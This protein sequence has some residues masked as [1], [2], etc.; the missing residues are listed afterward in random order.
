MRPALLLALLFIGCAH[1]Q[2]RSEPLPELSRLAL[3]SRLADAS[4]DEGGG[5]F[6]P[7][8]PYYVAHETMAQA[9]PPVGSPSWLAQAHS[10]T[11]YGPYAL[12]IVSPADSTVA[13]CFDLATQAGFSIG[14]LRATSVVQMRSYGSDDCSGIG[15]ILTQWSVNVNGTIAPLFESTAASGS[16]GFALTTNGARLD[17]GT[18]AN[19]YLYSDGTQVIAQG[20]V[21]VSGN[22]HVRANILNDVGGVNPVE[23]NDADGFRLSSTAALPTCSVS[24]EGTFKRDGTT[25]AASTA[26]TRMCWCTSDGAASPAYAWVNSISGTVGTATTCAP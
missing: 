13:V 6:L 12:K 18:G 9:M 2:R 4:E 11:L 7:V 8:V 17:L 20:S 26:R 24:L 3:Q 23:V 15:T 5:G 14:L 21:I 19:D 22:L 10:L 16:N 25:G 1:Q